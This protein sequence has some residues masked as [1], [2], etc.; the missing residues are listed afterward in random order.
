MQNTQFIPY[1]SQT[2]PEERKLKSM[3]LLKAYPGRIP[4]II[5]K[6]QKLIKKE[7]KTGAILPNQTKTKYLFNGNDQMEIVTAFVKRQLDIE[8]TQSI[9]LLVQ[10]KYSMSGNTLIKDV[11][12][13][14]KDE[15]GF[16]YFTFATEL[17]WG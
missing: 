4:V 13:K 8:A 2:T 9:F 5:E 1:K 11:Y 7:E 6:D 10:N 3:E 15:D 17:V 14:H 12:Q 16:L